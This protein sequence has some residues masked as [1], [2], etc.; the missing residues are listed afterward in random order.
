M[1]NKI[2][3][4]I[5]R[6]PRVQETNRKLTQLRGLAGDEWSRENLRKSS[7]AGECP[8]TSMLLY[9]Q[10]EVLPDKSIDHMM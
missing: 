3:K 10:C 4:I 1:K 8:L 9:Y 2:N 6:L 5:E 7:E